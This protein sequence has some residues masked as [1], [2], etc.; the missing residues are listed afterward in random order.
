MYRAAAYIVFVLV[1][2][3]VLANGFAPG[4]KK[5]LGDNLS[6][7]SWW[8][9]LLHLGILGAAVVM[10][11]TGYIP[12]VFQDKEVLGFWG[13]V[14]VGTAPVFAAS[15]ALITVTWADRCRID[16][17]TVKSA[18]EMH[19]ARKL[20][21]W[22]AVLL[23]SLLILTGIGRMN[24]L[25]GPEGQQRLLQLHQGFS[26]AFLLCIPTHWVLVQ[27]LAGHTGSAAPVESTEAPAEA[28]VR[29]E[30]SGTAEADAST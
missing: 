19:P 21:F 20:L 17:D 8:E 5:S 16:G 26:L 3:I 30:D 22:L 15:M 11:F 24:P 27:R 2:L 4:K 12:S 23:A 25:F 6:A 9:K 18:N 29:S 13:L 14:H 10:A 1:V 7:L 28:A